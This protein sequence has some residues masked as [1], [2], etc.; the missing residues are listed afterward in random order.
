TRWLRDAPTKPQTTNAVRPTGGRFCAPLAMCEAPRATATALPPVATRSGPAN[1]TTTVC[2]VVYDPVIMPS[3]AMTTT[4]PRATAFPDRPS[5]APAT[6]S[7]APET[8][9]IPTM[10]PAHSW[11]SS[12]P[13]TFFTPVTTTEPPFFPTVGYRNVSRVAAM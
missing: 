9:N 2:A 4:A 3:T 13:P 8:W 12:V 6:V 7:I 10:T 5:A 1:G 11:R